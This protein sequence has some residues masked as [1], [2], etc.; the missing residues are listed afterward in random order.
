M[1]GELLTA[2]EIADYLKINIQ[3]VWK[4]TRERKI[5][6]AGRVGRNYLFRKESIDNWMR[7]NI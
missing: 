2:R 5:P 4:Y 7:S 1:N 6:I 3:T